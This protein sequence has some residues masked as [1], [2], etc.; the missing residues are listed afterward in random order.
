M[1]SRVIWLKRHAV[2]AHPVRAMLAKS[3]IA[4]SRNFPVLRSPIFIDRILLDTFPDIGG[5]LTLATFSRRL[6]CRGIWSRCASSSGWV[7]SDKNQIAVFEPK[8]LQSLALEGGDFDLATARL[9]GDCDGRWVW[10]DSGLQ[11]LL[12][13]NGYVILRRNLETKVS[14]F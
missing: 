13:Q 2:I 11:D 3:C 12:C 14:V 5:R 4:P 9:I 8:G 1:V 7:I 6:V 10:I